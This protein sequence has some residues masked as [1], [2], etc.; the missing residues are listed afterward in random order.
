LVNDT[1]LAHYTEEH[2]NISTQKILGQLTMATGTTKPSP[3]EHL[4]HFADITSAIMNPHTDC[5]HDI[6]RD[7]C[8]KIGFDRVY[9]E[10]YDHRVGNGEQRNCADP[11]HNH[12]IHGGS[13]WAEAFYSILKDVRAA[14]LPSMFMT[15]GIFEQVGGTGFDILLGLEWGGRPIWHSIYGGYGYATGKAG[16]TERTPLDNG[17][18]TMLTS[19]FMAGGTMGWFTYHDYNNTFFLHENS[20]RV[21]YI[22][23]LSAV[24]IAV[25][26]WMVHGCE[27]RSL[28]IGKPSSDPEAQNNLKDACFLRDGQVSSSPSV[29]CAIAACNTSGTYS[30]NLQ[31]ARYGLSAGAKVLLTDL[32]T[33]EALGSYSGNVNHSATL[34]GYSVQL[35]KL[36]AV[37]RLKT[38]DRGPTTVDLSSAWGACA[39]TISSKPGAF[40]DT[41]PALNVSAT[42]PGDLTDDLVA[43]GILPHPWAAP[44]DPVAN[45][46]WAWRRR[47]TWRCTFAVPPPS[48]GARSWLR[49][50]AADYNVSVVF[51]GAVLG[52]HVGAMEAF[53]FDATAVL[54]N[55]AN[56]LEIVVEPMIGG[57]ASQ[58]WLNDHA[59]RW[60][61]RT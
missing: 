41:H 36:V 32:L 18:L 2:A 7:T 4:E 54:Q 35:L 14:V 44:A 52:R 25:K 55:T 22:R 10:S 15:K 13:F 26:A 9:I 61:A 38:D 48:Q 30:L 1:R 42:V 34:A 60:K 23:K 6:M 27:T 33:G 47:W 40:N 43:G 58:C 53:E 12:T 51:N 59:P 50:G 21:D 20:G 17:L 8:I 29:L 57:D 24:Q 45:M 49:F 31:P 19:Q 16:R 5:W 28:A 37:V 56:V 39:W 3:R 46:T 11:A